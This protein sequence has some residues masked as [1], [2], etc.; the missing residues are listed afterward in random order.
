MPKLALDLVGNAAPGVASPSVG[1]LDAGVGPLADWHGVVLMVERR[2]GAVSSSFAG[3]RPFARPPGVRRREGDVTRG[4]RN[5]Q[6]PAA[7]AFALA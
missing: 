2:R 7:V 3:T 5:H 1:G 6:E 4:G